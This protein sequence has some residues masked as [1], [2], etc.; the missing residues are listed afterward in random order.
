MKV[1]VFL[2]KGGS[3][4]LASWR[5]PALNKYTLIKFSSVKQEVVLPRLITQNS[6]M[7]LGEGRVASFTHC[8]TLPLPVG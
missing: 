1:R 5:R 7:T 4:V 8:V 6:F 3:T 2:L